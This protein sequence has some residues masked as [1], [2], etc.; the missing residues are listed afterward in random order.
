[1]GLGRTKRGGATIGLWLADTAFEGFAMKSE[2]LDLSRFVLGSTYSRADIAHL[3]M[4]SPKNFSWPTGITE[5]GNAVLLFVTL[6][7]TRYAYHDQFEGNLF[8]WQSQTRQ[9][10]VNPIL[11]SIATGEREPHLFVRVREKNPVT[12]PFVYCGRLS[13]P[14]MEGERPVTCQ[15]EALDVLSGATGELAR[16]YAWRPAAPMEGAEAARRDRLLTEELAAPRA[17]GQGRMRDIQRRRAVERHAMDVAIKHYTALGYAVTDTSS[18]H[19]FDLV[20]IRDNVKKRVEVKGTQSLGLSVD[21]T[22]G[23]VESALH[24]QDGDYS[25]DL[26]IVHSIAL[27]GSGELLHASGGEV[28]KIEN[29]SPADADLR[30]TV[31]R[32]QVPV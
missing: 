12:L 7:K 9:T 21:V 16:I 28:R 29:W 20:C 23:E 25:T 27:T 26:F 8:W 14:L 11:Q 30:A 31:F 18:T 24:R 3:G 4:V 17:R 5:F 6:E 22:I 19:P 13:P 15:F 10:Q 32:Y 2:I 1:L